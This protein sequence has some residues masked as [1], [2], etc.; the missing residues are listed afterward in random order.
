M[1]AYEL[2]DMFLFGTFNVAC[3]I[4]KSTFME[5]WLKPNIEAFQKALIANQFDGLTEVDLMQNHIDLMDMMFQHINII[6]DDL[7]ITH[8][9][10]E[11]IYDLYCEYAAEK[12]MNNKQSE[13]STDDFRNNFLS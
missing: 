5:V 13:I 10:A 6:P 2:M 11:I 3:K 4:P 7:I 1:I 12:I 9:N 8:N